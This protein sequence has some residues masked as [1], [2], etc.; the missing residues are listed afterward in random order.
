[1]RGALLLRGSILALCSASVPAYAQIETMVVTAEKREATV[2]ETPVAVSAF[3]SETRDLLGILSISDLTDL[4]PGATFQTF[5]NRLTIRG[6]G[7][8]DNAQ[9]T[10][11][12][13]ATYNDGAYTSETAFLQAP[14]LFVDRIEIV[15]GPQGTLFGRNA[16]GGAANVLSRRPEFE[17]SAEARF[18]Y[19]SFDRIDAQ[20]TFTGPVPYLED[21]TAFR[22]NA[23]IIQ[24][25]DG[26]QENLNAE[27]GDYARQ[28]EFYWL[29]GQLTHR[30]SDK[31]EGWVRF[32][33]TSD[34]NRPPFD[35]RVEEFQFAGPNP[36]NPLTIPYFSSLAPNALYGL[37]EP[38]IQVTDPFKVNLDFTPLNRVEDVYQF[39][40][41]LVW[42]TSFADIK[43][44][45]F[46]GNYD[47]EFFT[48][49][50][51][52]NRAFHSLDPN[53]P[54]QPDPNG[55]ITPT[56]QVNY[57]GDSKRW[58][59]HEIQLTSNDNDS[60]LRWIA[61]LYYYRERAG[62]PFD[63]RLPDA[64]GFDQA[65]PIF[66]PTPS[67]D[68][69]GF[70]GIFCGIFE[71]GSPNPNRNYYH[72]DGDL[73]AKAY[74]AYAQ[75]DY[76]FSP[77][78]SA[79]AGIRY[80]LDEKTGVE[81]QDLYAFNPQPTGV[82]GT[83]FNSVQLTPNDN[84]RTLD[85][86]WSAVTGT[87][88]LNWTPSE[89][90]LAYIQYSRGYKSG[91]FRLGQL[92]QDDPLTPDIDERFVEEE[93][94]NAF[95]IGAK[96]LFFNDT[97][98]LATAAFYYDY[99]DQQAPVNFIIPGTAIQ[100]QLFVNVP[101][102]RSLGF[103]LE[104]QWQPTDALSVNFTYAYLGTKVTEFDQLLVNEPLANANPADSLVSVV[105]NTL[106]RAPRNTASINAA[107]TFFFDEVGTLTFVT[108][109]IYVGSQHNTLF[110]DPIYTVDANDTVNLR[111][112]W[113]SAD[114]RFTL[115]ASVTNIFNDN[116]P[117][118]AVA[119][120]AAGNFS[121]IEDF[122]NRRVFLVE[123]QVRF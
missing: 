78:W 115:I 2:L 32:L 25:F 108:D 51:G 84:T 55:I 90:T 109:W 99:T 5:P 17:Y 48:D 71:L 59:S 52:T 1:M 70:P 57:I 62:Q 87:A 58:H 7:R 120:G 23:A 91:G 95:E 54:T 34:R 8:L 38:N 68:C 69:F 47:W 102:S 101:K 9:G 73:I 74:A 10:D 12:G 20:G 75:I 30:F 97:L 4:T 82:F 6:I 96:G 46:Y 61:G 104:G 118:S 79:K 65:P 56:N 16:I 72:Q 36:D 113:N 27:A 92:S 67:P 31:V 89:S 28:A 29:E 63:L 98:S 106:P 35:R 19:S 119:A 14:P 121:R 122:L 80:T 64:E 94:V 110:D 77:K 107:Y 112:L 37:T 21:T 40:G 88:G 3:S 85:N 22:V 103:E 114:D 100:Q 117:N 105:G 50:D 42:E 15:R 81:E 93:T 33:T 60:D 24:Q 13:V 41:E 86:T 11:P 49:A 66:D 39:W 76:D 111:A 83:G 53:D 26:A 45:G 43:Y 44:L 123:A 18:R 116:T